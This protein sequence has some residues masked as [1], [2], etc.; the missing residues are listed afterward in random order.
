M[1]QEDFSNIYDNV[2]DRQFKET[3]F[4]LFF[5]ASETVKT[6]DPSIFDMSELDKDPKIMMKKIIQFA[7]QSWSHIITCQM[8]QNGW[9][10]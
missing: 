7:F 6:I 10:E 4:Q 8:K 9:I 5:D 3:M 1:N 2:N